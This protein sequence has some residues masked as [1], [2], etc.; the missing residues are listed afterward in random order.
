MVRHALVVDNNPVI[1]RLLQHIL[2]ERNLQVVTAVN[3]LAALEILEKYRP[4]IIF[5]DLV[6]PYIGG[7]KL[8]RILRRRQEHIQTPLIV[9]SAIALE[10]DV[11]FLAFGANAC[12]AKGP[13]AQ[14]TANI[15]LVLSLVKGDRLDLLSGMRLGAES[16]VHRAMT[17][18]LLA[19]RHHLQ[20]LLE[21]TD[22]G[23]IEFSLDG[24]IVGSNTLARQFFQEEETALLGREITQLFMGDGGHVGDCIRR[25][26]EHGTTVACDRTIRVNGLDLVFKI[27]PLISA[28]S[29]SSL[30]VLRDVT[31]EKKARRQLKEHLLQLE[32]TIEERTSD[33]AEANLQLQAGME[34]AR[35]MHEQMELA[36]RQWSHTF[37]TIPDFLSVHD[38]EL[39]FVRV[40]KALADFLGQPA[41][42]LIGNH[43]YK[44]LHGLDHPWEGCPHQQAIATG[45]ITTFEVNDPAIGVVLEVTC[46]P[47]LDEDGNLTGTVHVARNISE[48]IKRT[49]ERENL[50]KQ[51]EDSLAKVKLLSGFLPICASCKKIRDDQGYWQQVEKYIRTHSEAQFSHSICPDCA[52]KLYPDLFPEDT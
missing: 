19:A 9:V 40:N 46:S 23:I 34:Q 20:T 16:I 36:A 41:E 29:T 52:H 42:K 2:E 48:R 39:R 37:D 22:S 17:S 49:R 6:M 50:I 26:R 4:D 12:I 43:C 18:E 1:L 30:M 5:T 13:A 32:A 3:G 14:M 31:E 7:E 44:L 47:L 33:L 10:D 27:H 8:C 28:A 21:N 45:E 25:F 38:R 24:K 11:D 15:D 35:Q 51:L